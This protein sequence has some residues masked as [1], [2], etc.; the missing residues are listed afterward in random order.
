MKSEF[1]ALKS[2]H[3]SELSALR[4]H[5]ASIENELAELE[6]AAGFKLMRTPAEDP[7]IPLVCLEPPHRVACRFNKRELAMVIGHD[8]VR[9]PQCRTIQLVGV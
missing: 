6:R 9:C 1:L 7:T 2:S 5:A 4:D 3:R 8:T